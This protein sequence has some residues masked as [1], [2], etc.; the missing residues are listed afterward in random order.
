MESFI[1][2]WKQVLP[3]LLSEVGETA[4]NVWI[5]E[6]TPVEMTATE[7]VFRL[8]TKMHYE[9]ISGRFTGHIK[10]F[11]YNVTGL[12]LAIRFVYDKPNVSNYI[13]DREKSV[14]D[15]MGA[16]EISYE[17]TFD[18]FV[19]GPTN[20]FACAA[21]QAVAKNPGVAYNPLFIYGDAGLGKTHLMFAIRDQIL[22]ND[23]TKKIVYIKGDEFTNDLV[24]AIKSGKQIEFRSKYRDADVLLM[25]DIQ[26]IAG[27]PQTQ[28]EFFHTFNTLYQDQKQIVLT[29][30]RPPREIKTLEERL[31]S[32][33]ESGLLA[34]IQQPEYET[35][36]A[37]IKNKANQLGFDLPEKTAEFIADKIKGNVRQLEGIVKKINIIC[38]VDGE[39]PNINVAGR[40]I[41]DV[42][43]EEPPTKMTIEKIVIEVARSFGVDPEDIYSS[44]RSQPLSTARQV[45]MYCVREI[46]DM[47][48]N[49]I[50]TEFG[51]RDH[52]TVIYAVQKVEARMTAFSDFKHSVEDLIKNLKQN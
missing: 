40:A 2:I 36:V 25:D 8:P 24:E 38:K 30:D 15:S 14:E 29:S 45:A 18:S 34:D 43:R 17:Y 27:K 22:R 20:R 50:G 19:I 44:K 4:Y 47:P 23:P 9:V 28:E 16:P 35:R 32:R 37:I 42:K 26:F 5:R 33:F 51:G 46:T 49:D 21:A 3:M 10:T 1:D 12:H 39:K 52:T 13:T 7:A 11:L 48:Y 41:A 31:T 6:I